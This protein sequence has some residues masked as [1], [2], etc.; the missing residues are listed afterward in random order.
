MCYIIKDAEIKAVNRTAYID[1]KNV[2]K[3]QRAVFVS[4]YENSSLTLTCQ[5]E[6]NPTNDNVMWYYYELSADGHM[7]NQVV[8]SSSS[9]ASTWTSSHRSGDDSHSD[10]APASFYSHLLLS[11][12]TSNHSGYYSCAISSFLVDSLN[13]TQ[14]LHVNSTYF[15]LVQCKSLYFKTNY[16]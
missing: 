11:N 14:A 9:T 13:R 4:S 2:L 1:Q 8:L 5:V 16:N 3:E 6:S 15:L 10:N 7:R 12:L